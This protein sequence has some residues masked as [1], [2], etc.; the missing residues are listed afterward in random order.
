MELS[1]LH[2]EILSSAF[3][4]ILGG[5]GEEGTLTFV[6]CLTSEIVNC[7]AQNPYFSVENWKVYTV[8]DRLDLSAKTISADYAVEIRE[9]KKNLTLLLVDTDSAGAGMDGIYSSAREVDEKTLFDKAKK[10][11]EKEIKKKLSNKEIY[12]YASHAIKV[13]KKLQPLSPW[14]EFDFLVKLVNENQYPGKLLYLLGLWPAK[15]STPS[16]LVTYKEELDISKSFIE[17]LLAPS[18][19]LTPSQRIDS[20]NLIISPELKKEYENFIVSVAG[21][22]RFEALSELAKRE[23]LWIDI[24][25]VKKSEIQKISLISWRGKKG[26]ILKWSGLESA[27]DPKDPPNLLLNSE[28]KMEVR[29]KVIPE[30]LEKGSVHYKVAILTDM[31]EEITSREV[32][33]IGKKEEKCIFSMDDFILEENPFTDVSAKVKLSVIGCENIHSEDSEEFIITFG[34]SKEQNSGVLGEKLRAFSEGLIE[35]EDREKV[36]ELVNNIDQYVSENDKTGW[37]IFRAGNPIKRYRIFRPR[38]LREVEEQWFERKGEIGRWRVKVRLSGEKAKKVEFVPLAQPS[39]N[40]LQK[41]WE[42]VTAASKQLS[43]QFK[44]THGGVGQVYYEKTKAFEISKEYILAWN[45][46]LEKGEPELALVNTIEV[47]S[48]SGRTIG[49]IV[50]PSHPLRVSWHIAYDN[51]VLYSGLEE[52]LKLQDIQKEF[53]LLDGAMFPAFLPGLQRE[54]AFIFADMLGFHLAGMV[55]DTEKEP[56]AAITLL[57]KALGESREEDIKPTVGNQSSQ[58]IGN[59]ILKYIKSHDKYKILKIHALRSGDGFTISRSLG[60]VQNQLVHE[61]DEDQAE[62]TNGH[63]FILELYP[64]KDQKHIAGEF[65]AKT[66]KKRR[67]GS[68]GAVPE[69]RWIFD[70]ISMP[71]GIN[72]PKLRWAQK[73]IDKPS[74]SAHLAIAFDTFDSRPFPIDGTKEFNDKPYHAYG[75]VTFFERIYTHDPFPTWISALLK[76]KEGVKHPSDRFHTERLNQLQEAVL[77]IVSKWMNW[78]GERVGLKT[79][80]SDEMKDDLQNLHLLSDWVVTMDR[81]AGIEY[82]DFPK[83]N[84]EIYDAYVID[85]VPEREDLGCMQMVTSTSRLEEVENILNSVLNQMGLSHSRRNIEFLMKQL[86]GLSGRLAIRLTGESDSVSSELIALAFSRAACGKINEV[87]KNDCWT[88]LKQGFFIPIDDIRDLLPPL[89]LDK[90]DQTRPDLIYV[91]IIPRKGLCFSFIEVKYRRNLSTARNAE[92]LQVIKTQIET[93]QDRWA[94]W[95]FDEKSSVLKNLRLTK[96]ARVLQFYLEKAHRHDLLEEPQYKALSMEIDKMVQNG[97]EY[98]FSQDSRKNR[99]WIF[100]PEFLGKEPIE[101]TPPNWDLQVF[102]FGSNGILDSVPV[103]TQEE[104]L[105]VQSR[106]ISNEENLSVKDVEP[107]EVHSHQPPPKKEEDSSVIVVPSSSTSERDEQSYNDHEAS[108]LLGED[109]AG[110]EVKWTITIKGNPH[111]L[112]TGLPGMG[113][114]TCLVNLCQQMFKNEISPIVF[115]YHQD[116]DEKLGKSI[117]PLRFIDF[118]GL[119]FNPLKVI[120]LQA[121]KAYLDVAADI[122]DIFKAIYPDIGDLQGE[123]I[124]K[125]IKESFE[126]LGWKNADTNLSSLK[127]PNFGRFFEILQQNP[128]P[129]KGLQN[130]MVR[131][132]ELHD[133]GFFE[134]ANEDKNLWESQEPILIRIHKTQNENLQKGFAALIFYKLYKDMFRRG[135]QKRITHAIIFDEAHR[136]AKLKHIP[137]MAKECRKYGISFILASQEAGDFDP[138][139]FSAVANYLVLRLNERDAKALVRNVARSDQERSLIDKIKQIEPYKALYFS[140]ERTRPVSVELLNY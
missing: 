79:E 95:Y 18:T 118:Q 129:D 5:G 55:L 47:Q 63:A 13:A 11:I 67:S 120:D 132:H 87:D 136:A 35:Y 10:W 86:K 117:S 83:V 126:E 57:L 28:T 1:N 19:S 96:L 97:S 42:R 32:S 75:L 134:T 50:L 27:S 80:L 4:E 76:S 2:A 119:G 3:S 138:S 48:L 14:K 71:N 52:N 33:H 8:S 81:N 44:K 23:Q 93:L 70:S 84:Q 34:E 133:Y 59:E 25:N 128:S 111:L 61:D 99:G 60:Y 24:N 39:D 115:S 113:K 36:A 101:I 20:L 37:V 112:I 29:W 123:Q 127:T 100:C 135:V 38:L 9:S 109:A 21:K 74:K 108:I 56:K 90:E 82:F 73:N 121:P 68:G 137:T 30:D 22:P 88:S 91:T 110:S 78:N 15:R 17:R 102:L 7:L 139:L 46:L 72:L 66:S 125:T 114:T 6:R 85:C 45:S 103:E 41:A 140:N 51:L 116:I 106:S 12:E 43:E 54:R 53:L 64:T 49:L 105:S 89:K 62:S 92:T 107:L 65:L 58:I 122:R 26:E 77:K 104:S 124:R 98:K 94:N 40:E 16:N 69:D 31:D 130:L 131:L